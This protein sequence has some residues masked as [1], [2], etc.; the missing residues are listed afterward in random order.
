MKVARV[1]DRFGVCR[2]LGYRTIE[3]GLWSWFFLRGW[4]VLKVILAF[5]LGSVVLFSPWIYCSFFKLGPW[6]Q[7]VFLYS[8][9]RNLNTYKTNWGFKLFVVRNTAA[10]A[11]SAMLAQKNTPKHPKTMVHRAYGIYMTSWRPQ[12]LKIINYDP[13]AKK[14]GKR[15]KRRRVARIPCV[16]RIYGNNRRIARIAENFTILEQLQEFLQSWLCWYVCMYV[17]IEAWYIYHDILI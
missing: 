3:V 9:N 13:N 7:V 12:L 2:L 15:G 14:T 6:A 17:C 8:P 5:T 16:A 11:G 4:H 1:L 10:L